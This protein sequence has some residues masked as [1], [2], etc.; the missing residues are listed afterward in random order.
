MFVAD[1]APPKIFT[2]TCAPRRPELSSQLL[3]FSKRRRSSEAMRKIF[4]NLAVLVLAISVF[5]NPS[6]AQRGSAPTT[7][8]QGAPGGGRGAQIRQFIKTDA[9]VIA[10]THVKV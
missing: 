6:A 2:K 3:E 8:P 10:L 5:A 4:C 7:A 9:P 1:S